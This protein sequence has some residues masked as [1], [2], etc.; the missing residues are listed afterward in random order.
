MHVYVHE[1]EFVHVPVCAAAST[2]LNLAEG[3]GEGSPARRAYFY[4]IARSSATEVA[5]ALDHTVDVGLLDQDA[6]HPAKELT[7][8]IVAMLYRLTNSITTPESYPPLPR[9]PAH[10]RRP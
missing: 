2:P 9:R 10:R 7:V 3:T 8:R 6:T 4:R 5:A 1:T